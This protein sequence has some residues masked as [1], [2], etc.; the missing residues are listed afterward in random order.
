MVS[1]Q[2]LEMP[3]SVLVLRYHFI[4]RMLLIYLLFYV[5]LSFMNITHEW[6]KGNYNE[7]RTHVNG[8]M[9]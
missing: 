3:D 5:L 2:E 1:A 6:K 8:E 4:M 7:K 9:T